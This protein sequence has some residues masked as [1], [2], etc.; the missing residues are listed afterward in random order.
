MRQEDVTTRDASRA[1][2]ADLAVGTTGVVRFLLGWP[3][4]SRE[5]GWR[6]LDVVAGLVCSEGPAAD[7]RG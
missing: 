2:A 7:E 5:W 3:A 1:T 6:L 4:A